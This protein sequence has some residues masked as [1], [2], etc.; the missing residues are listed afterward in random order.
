MNYI[1]L[2]AKEKSRNHLLNYLSC[3]TLVEAPH[4]AKDLIQVSLRNVL[5][6]W[7]YVVSIVKVGIQFCDVR[8]RRQPVLY[9][10]LFFHLFE[11]IIVIQQLLLHFLDCYEAL[12]TL[13]PGL[14]HLT[15]LAWAN[16]FKCLKVINAERYL[17]SKWLPHHLT[18][19]RINGAGALKGLETVSF[20][21]C[22]G[23]RVVDG[24]VEW[25]GLLQ[26][27]H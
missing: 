11:E 24:A 6:H 27:G 19:L 4:F 9:L 12:T 15:E 22:L 1:S 10:Q 13:F 3:Y 14:D 2:L 26:C 21:A 7:V 25:A 8:M 16:F 5:E 17:R 18:G 23:G 20:A